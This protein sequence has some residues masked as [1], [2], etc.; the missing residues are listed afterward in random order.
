M[1]DA[2]RANQHNSY[3]VVFRK[4]CAYNELRQVWDKCQTQVKVS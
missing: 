2:V 3:L 1:C 4:Q